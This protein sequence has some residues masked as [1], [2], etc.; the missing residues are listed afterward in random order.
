M[1]VVSRQTGR[2]WAV[3]A[4]GVAVLVWLL[5]T[6]STLGA[7]VGG[8]RSEPLS[9]VMNPQVLLRRA[10]DSSSVPH[11]GLAESRGGLAF[12]DLP[13]LGDLPAQLGGTT[14]LRVWWSGPTAWRVDVPTVTGEQ[15]VY[16]GPQTVLWDYEES[17][18]TRVVG[19]PS[20]RLPRADDLLPPQ[21]ARRLL[22]GV[23]D[24][25]LVEVVAGQAPIA[26][27]RTQGLRIVPADPRSTIGAIDIRLETVSGLPLAVTV[28][29]ASG[30]TALESRFVELELAAPDPVT[31]QVP[32]APGA[33]HDTATAPDLVS[34]IERSGAWVLPDQLADLPASEPVVGGAA[35]YGTGL[36]RFVVLPLSPRLGARVVEAT[37]SEGSA[38]SLPGGEA[39]LIT[40]GPVTVVVARGADGEHAY[41]IS[42]LVTSA[43]LSDAARSLFAAPPP[44]R[45]P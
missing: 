39:R 9:A 23:D 6:A 45:A 40:S 44:Q 4:A 27:R 10:W 28:V 42:G 1:S 20:L 34:R 12:P 38:L 13:R 36:V 32:A 33:V 5:A 31:L 3:V 19:A 30:R 15:G 11:Y 26:G 16:G 43:L 25:D 17:R 22:A 7:W 21:A 2:R 35:T 41:L 37:R 24:R 8:V 18:L 29:D 14:R